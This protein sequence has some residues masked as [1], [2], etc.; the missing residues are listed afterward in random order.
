MINLIGVCIFNSVEVVRQTI[1]ILLNAPGLPTH[2]ALIYNHPPDPDK[3]ILKFLRKLAK[4]DERVVVCI[5]EKNLG[6][7][8]GI[9]YAW[10][11]KING[12]YKYSNFFKV[13]DDVLVPSGFDIPM[14]KVNEAK[15]VGYSVLACT[16]E[17]QNES[18]VR[19]EINGVEV[20]VA[21]GGCLSFNVMAVSNE[22]RKILGDL[23]CHYALASGGTRK[24][25]SDNERLYGGEEAH[26]AQEARKNKLHI[27]KVLSPISEHLGNEHRDPDYVLWKYAY[28]YLGSIDCE[29]KEFKA[30]KELVD[31]EFVKYATFLRSHGIEIGDRV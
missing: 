10:K 2:F 18:V 22:S 4:R 29:L 9:N 13:D 20:D 3:K 27:C 26:Y 11:Q 25:V 23:G 14:A 28:G 21:E 30:D 31:R 7:H 16:A 15:Q 17:Q 5:P 8:N 19:R 6:C 1:P 12:Q 24:I